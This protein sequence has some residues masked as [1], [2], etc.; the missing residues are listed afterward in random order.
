VAARL[1]APPA[2]HPG[3]QRASR[4][5][6]RE[7]LATDAGKADEF[8]AQAGSW[9]GGG[10]DGWRGTGSG[11]DR[12]KWPLNLRPREHGGNTSPT[13]RVHARVTPRRQS[14]CACGAFVVAAARACP[15]FPPRNLNGKEGVDGSSPSE[16][17]QNRRTAALSRSGRLALRRSWGG[18]GAVYGAFA[19]ATVTWAL[20]V[21]DV[22]WPEVCLS[23]QFDCAWF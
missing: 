5:H 8:S 15:R 3:A 23:E 14:P 2:P 6:D 9:E 13:T 16:A 12:R 10:D 7:R 1:G 11:L 19:H 20:S 17:L 18:Y 4:S 21:V 22:W